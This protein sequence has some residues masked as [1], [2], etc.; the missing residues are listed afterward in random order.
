[1]TPRFLRDEAA[2]FRGMAET[3]DREAT[4]LRLLA[5]ATDYDARA[6]VA[7]DVSIPEPS[8][9][10]AVSAEPAHDDTPQ[11]S[12]GRKVAKGLRGRLG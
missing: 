12:L 7:D 10:I 3:T 9:E 4:K 11:V 8:D 1:M 2:R 5:M 6:G